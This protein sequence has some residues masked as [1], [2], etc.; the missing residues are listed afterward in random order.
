MNDLI[1]EQAGFMEIMDKINQKINL[2]SH[3]HTGSELT[4]PGMIN[5]CRH[6]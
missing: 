5:H 4:E 2:L 1:S 6:V 3:R